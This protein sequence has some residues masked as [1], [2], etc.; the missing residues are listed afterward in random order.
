MV[1]ISTIYNIQ[2]VMESACVSILSSS[3]GITEVYTSRNS[4]SRDE[5]PYVRVGYSGQAPTGI[6]HISGSQHFDAMWNANLAVQVVTERANTN[7]RH[8]TY[9]SQIMDILSRNNLFNTGLMPNHYVVYNKPTS[10]STTQDE[11]G[12]FDASIIQFNVRIYANPD[13]W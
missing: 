8:N 13:S 4:G 1:T 3:L 12:F 10:Y 7:Y 9:V 6:V 5:F 2:P 11:D